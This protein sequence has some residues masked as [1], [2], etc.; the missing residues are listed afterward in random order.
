M[1]NHWDGVSGN[2]TELFQ[3]G[4]QIKR[5]KDIYH[6]GPKHITIIKDCVNILRY[7]AQEEDLVARQDKYTSC[8]C[9]IN[10]HCTATKIPFLY[11]QNELRGLSPNFH[12][13]VPVSDLYIPRIIGLNIFLQ[14]SSQTDRGNI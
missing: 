7:L 3:D 5:E 13:H 2:G 4:G 12:I 10:P 1:T 6:H 8:L 11:S 14:Q 9:T